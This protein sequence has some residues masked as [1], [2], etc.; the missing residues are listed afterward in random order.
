[1]AVSLWRRCWTACLEPMTAYTRAGALGCTKRLTS[2]GLVLPAARYGY[3]ERVRQGREFVAALLDRV[4]G[5]LLKSLQAQ[6]AQSA[7]LRDDLSLPDIFPVPVRACAALVVKDPPCVDDRATNGHGMA[8]SGP[9]ICCFLVCIILRPSGSSSR[10]TRVSGAE[11]I[12]YLTA[13]APCCCRT[14]TSRRSTQPR[15]AC[16]AGNWS[17]VRHTTLACAQILCLVF[18]CSY[19]T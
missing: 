15:T 9:S 12:W 19:W 5:L 2:I 13:A 17:S 8:G 7:A 11:Q 6:L 4:I 16:G 3:V 14:R 10:C 1:M 18:L